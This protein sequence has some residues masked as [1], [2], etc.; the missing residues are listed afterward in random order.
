[1]S[2]FH[3]GSNRRSDSI[4]SSSTTEDTPVLPH[5]P[6]LDESGLGRVEYGSIVTSDVAGLSD[7]LDSAPAA[8][9][10]RA[11]RTYT[12]YRPKD[13]ASIGKY[14]LENGNEKARL[15]FLSTFPNWRESTIRN[16]KE[17]YESQ[18]SVERKK[19]NPE[20]VTELTTKPKGR[21]PVLLDLDEKLIFL[22]A[23]RSKGG[24][25][26]IHVVRATG[27]ALIETHLSSSQHLN[28][29]MP[30][31][32]VQSIFKKMGYSCR[33]GTTACPPVPKGLYD[34]SR[35]AFC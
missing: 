24:V 32:W 2:L 25:V 14:A 22:T 6:F 16:F 20:P 12:T 21:P 30:R 11:H 19:V 10:C 8:K 29:S 27:K 26:N 7:P 23:I 34:E 17:A 13:C 33:M 5:F 18:L 15:H 3:F 4:P 9:K 1:M 31:S 28:F 35:F